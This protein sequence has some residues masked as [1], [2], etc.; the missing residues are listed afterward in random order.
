MEG[1]LGGGEEGISEDLGSILGTRSGFESPELFRD[2]LAYVAAHLDHESGRSWRPL[3]DTAIS[4]QLLFGARD[5]Y[6]GLRRGLDFYGEGQLVCVQVDTLI[7][8]LS[9]GA[10]SIDN[11]CQVFYGGEGRVAVTPYT[12]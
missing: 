1:E 4:G 7:R 8:R 3:A 2:R 6:A 10:K 11:F 5:D 12:L 9:H